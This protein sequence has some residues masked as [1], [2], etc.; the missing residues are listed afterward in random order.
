MKRFFLAACGAAMVAGASAQIANVDFDSYADG[1]LAGQGSPAWNVQSS[2]ASYHTVGASPYALG[3]K[4]YNVD[5][6]PLGVGN[7]AWQDYSYT[8]VGGRTIVVA[9]S[10][11][12]IETDPLD[13]ASSGMGIDAYQGGPF[14]RMAGI[15]WFVE[16]GGFTG[17]VDLV[18]DV[19]IVHPTLT[20]VSN[21]RYLAT[22]CMNLST[23]QAC[24]FFD[25]T[26]VGVTTPVN[27]TSYTV[28]SSFTDADNW[29]VATG[30][31]ILHHDN[32]TID[33][34][35]PGTIRG[36]VVLQD[37]VASPSGQGVAVEI[38]DSAGMVVLDTQYT[39]LNANGVFEVSTAVRG[40][41]TIAVKGNKWLNRLRTTVSNLTDFGVFG[42]SYSLI[43]ADCNND[44]AVDI[45]DY[46]IISGSYNLGLG[47]AGYDPNSD[48][49]G[50]DACDIADYAI[51]S[52]N[53]GLSG[54]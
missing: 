9:Q 35:V 11:G 45:A 39:T 16:G 52:S 41:V 42:I 54:D 2:D 49:N 24:A 15:L 6:G 30:Y 27:M 32:L 4:S 40:A 25:D 12:V 22:L 17:E 43:A 53:Y 20:P 34:V 50:D 31:N 36:S 21:T 46:A 7:W 8:P 3:T 47:D 10:V 51:L 26:E 23:A 18:G 19:T 29:S 38:R 48:V 37:W 1:A 44:N 5:T 33:A 28:G 14:A 13:R